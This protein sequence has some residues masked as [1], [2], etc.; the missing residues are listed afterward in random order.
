[1]HLFRLLQAERL[2][3]SW[4]NAGCPCRK[5]PFLQPKLAIFVPISIGRHTTFPLPLFLSELHLRQFKNHAERPF[6]L[7]EHLNA[8]TG[9]NGTGKTNVLDAIYYLCLCKSRFGLSDRELVLQGEGFF[10]L[11]GRFVLP[12]GP[13][14]VTAKVAPPRRKEFLLG[15]VPYTR[16]SDH[17]GRLPLVMIAPDD[18]ELALGGSEI[19]RAFLD[20]ALSQTDPEYLAALMQY[21]RLLEQRNALLKQ[22][23]PPPQLRALLEAFDA[24]MVPIGKLIHARRAQFVEA[25][26]P[27]FAA[28]YAAISG[29]REVP[30]L[31][32]G[33]PLH[34]AEFSAI[35]QSRFEKDRLLRRTTG[36]PHRDDLQLELDGREVKR[37]A[38][39]GQLKSFVLAMRLAQY[40]YLR[41]A[42]G[43]APL[44]LLDD[45]FDKLD[46]QRVRQLLVLLRERRY[47]QIFLTDTHADR[48]GRLLEE[49]DGEKRIFEM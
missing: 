42:R 36:G 10:R 14:T 41:D 32:Y 9:P 8:F 12:D 43:T 40:E 39:Q 21:N 47:G 22:D 44:L 49:L 5:T 15:E 38:S 18:T 6:V 37:Y 29:A 19:R 30:A 25:F 17:I 16:L 13:T 48:V 24:G 45:I 2:P 3:F 7:A 31:V 4:A 23:P 20:I 27:R 34:E 35:L 11:D 1:M 28:C 26:L 46:A 33:S